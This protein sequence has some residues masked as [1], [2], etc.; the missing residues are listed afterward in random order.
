M[1]EHNDFEH[2]ASVKNQSVI[3]TK[4]KAGLKIGFIFSLEMRV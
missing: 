3:I 1:Y 4:L 2:V